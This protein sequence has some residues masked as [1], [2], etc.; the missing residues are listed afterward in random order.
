MYYKE[1]NS[2]DIITGILET[3][4]IPEDTQ[5]YIYTEIG[6]EE[7]E[8]LKSSMI[9]AAQPQPQPTTDDYL[10]DLDYRIS[11]IELGL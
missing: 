10:V 7:Y 5:D 8:N 1:I 4:S 2:A 9:Q 3:A 6:E 11:C